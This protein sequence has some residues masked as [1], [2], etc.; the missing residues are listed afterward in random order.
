MIGLRDL[1]R[2]LRGAGGQADSGG[3]RYRSV[4]LAAVVLAAFYGVCMGFFGLFARGDE[5]EYRQALACAAKVPL[6]FVLALAVTFPSL[7]VFN[8]LI[9]S[10]LKLIDLARML[11]ASMGVVTAVLAGFGPIVAFFSV[12]TISY[13]FA[14]LMNVAA[15]AVAAVFG[16]VHLYRILGVLPPLVPPP[17]PPDGGNNLSPARRE[18]RQVFYLWTILFALVGGQMSWVLRPFIGSPYQEFTWFRPR[19]GS[20]FEAVLRSFRALLEG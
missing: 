6:L 20:F 9:G 8:T 14:V 10:R 18:S 3:V 19:G 16:L 17:A 5:W 12:T 4:A 15:F 1:D 7:Y 11:T 13:P 2:I